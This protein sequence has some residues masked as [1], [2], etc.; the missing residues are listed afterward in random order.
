MREC[1]K[2]ILREWW[3]NWSW[4]Y[5]KTTK[6]QDCSCCYKTFQHVLN[7]ACKFIVIQQI[8]NFRDW[9]RCGKGHQIHGVDIVTMNRYNLYKQSGWVF[10]SDCLN[11]S[12]YLPV[13]SEFILPKSLQIC[14]SVLCNIELWNGF[15]FLFKG[16]NS[17]SFFFAFFPHVST[18]LKLFP[19]EL[20]LYRKHAG[21][22]EKAE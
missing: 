18:H 19:W 2:R 9:Q 10:C 21:K 15:K 5:T 11:Y 22:M 16:S 3:H 17:T 6:L 1:I 7:C 14:K 8:Q 13:K 4:S 20:I 12:I